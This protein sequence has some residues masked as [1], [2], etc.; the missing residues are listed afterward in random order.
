ML[1]NKL[2]VQEPSIEL[3]SVNDTS[4]LIVIRHLLEKLHSEDIIYCHWK[5]NE[6]VREG[7]L[8]LTDLD[9]L[10]DKK[11]YLQLQKVLA[12]SGFK[13]F[14]ATP[15]NGYPGVD[16]YLAMDG[17]TGKLIHLH[18]HYQLVAGVAHLKGTHLPWEDLVL[19]TRIYDQKNQIYV[20]DPNVEMILLI[21]RAALKIRSRDY[22]LDRLGKKYFRGDFAREFFWL[23]ER[24]NLDQIFGIASQLLGDDEGLKLQQIVKSEPSLKQLRS[25]HKKSST[26][27]L[28]RT[29][30]PF[31][32]TIR[33]WIRELLWGLGVINKRYLHAATPLRRIPATGG[34]LIA[35]MGC[36]GSGKSTQ[37]K[38][39]IKWLSWKIDVVPV[40]FGSGEGSSSLIRKPL[41]I[42]AKIV[43]NLPGLKSNRETVK[44]LSQDQKMTDGSNDPVLRKIARI[45]WALVLA[46]E[47]RNKIRKATKAKNRG[48]VVVC[49]RYPQNQI[50]GFNDG[51]LISY[52]QKY[53][54]SFLRKLADWESSPYQWAEQN[55]PDIVIKLDVTP[56]VALARKADADIGE[57]QR[58]VTAIK[59]FKYPS[60]TKVVLINAEE[61]LDV[62][63]LKV[64]SAIWEAL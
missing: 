50:M 1:D 63:L 59:S 36:D 16:D 60:K 19:N 24:I 34:L 58:R 46:Y 11:C 54:F 6:H 25:L 27:H 17:K 18:L 53:H 35:L 44:D 45:P 43:R 15:N 52:L 56:E 8:G 49:D 2:E 38:A 13:R 22:L 26:L 29:Y 39:L 3:S 7:M 10:V 40:Y 37:M 32:A 4:S 57:Y 55:P 51:P 12:E 21:V 41:N 64:K 5:S 42:L 23:K 33:R 28:F 48:M 31:E 20:V 14:C 47:K 61:P 30:H 9:V 62:V